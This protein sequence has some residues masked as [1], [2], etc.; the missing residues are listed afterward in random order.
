[1]LPLP[2]ASTYPSNPASATRLDPK[3]TIAHP[4][5]SRLPNGSI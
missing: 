1:M 5:A 3:F 4:A 2:N